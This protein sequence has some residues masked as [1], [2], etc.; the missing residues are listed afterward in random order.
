L[1]FLLVFVVFIIII[2]MYSYFFFIFS[3]SKLQDTTRLTR[4]LTRLTRPHHAP[5]RFPSHDADWHETSLSSSHCRRCTCFADGTSRGL[6]SRGFQVHDKESDW[7]H[8]YPEEGTRQ[9]AWS[10]CRQYSTVRQHMTTSDSSMP[11]IML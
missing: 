11:R 6:S 8:C 2:F 5:R 4:L 10:I 7:C 9:A 3:T 1:F